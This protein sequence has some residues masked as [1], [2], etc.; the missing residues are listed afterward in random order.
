MQ[1]EHLKLALDKLEAELITTS[2][3]T[4]QTAT[5]KEDIE[6]QKVIALQQQQFL[7]KLRTIQPLGR[8]VIRMDDPERLRGTPDDLELQE[9]DNLQIPQ[10]QQTVNVM[11]SVVNPTAVVYDPYL[12]V[13]KYIAQV[14]G[15]TKHADTDRLYVIKVNGSALG[16]K[17]GLIFGR[18]VASSR[19]DPGDT[20]VVPEKLERIPWLKTVKDVATI[21]G[22]FALM[23]GVAVS[24]LK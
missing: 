10:I 18:R 11:G 20:I 23:A 21:L 12:T 19:L 24:V 2:V 3:Q 14:G 22:Q 8:V 6:R 15:P 1:A 9:G 7:A 13:G 4:T 16:E 5:D 17:G